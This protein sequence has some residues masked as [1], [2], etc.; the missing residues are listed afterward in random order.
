M[1]VHKSSVSVIFQEG[2]D[3]FPK[4]QSLQSFMNALDIAFDNSE[5]W[6]WILGPVSQKIKI[7]LPVWELEQS[8]ELQ[9]NF[10]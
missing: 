6:S 8:G 1:P 2:T 10:A 3:L 4:S 7:I 9:L 5:C